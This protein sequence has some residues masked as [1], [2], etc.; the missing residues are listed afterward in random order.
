MTPQ[1]PVP[2]T[3][4]DLLSR[5]LDRQAAAQG[6]GLAMFEAGQVTPYDAGPVQ[7]IDP[8]PAWAEAVTALG[9]TW[10]GV[11]LA[12]P[13][14]WPQLVAS[15]EPVVA[16]AWCVGN[17]P[18]LVRNFHAILRYDNLAHLRPAGGRPVNAPALLEWA[19]QVAAQ[20]QFPEAILAVGAL[21]L[22]QHFDQ[23]SWLLETLDRDVPAAW[24]AVWVNER[25]ALAWHRGDADEAVRQWRA[26]EPTLPVRFNRAMADLFSG[27]AVDSVSSRLKELVVHLP[28]TSGW[29]HLARLYLALAK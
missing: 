1:R 12:P 29:H 16:L 21:R 28:E 3:L 11:K 5:Y 2:P 8:Q 24:R 27:N 15:H 13:P 26:A 25:A 7:P 10:A 18:Q 23:A 17:F 22:A 19:Q 4:D 14:H 9:P 20:Q 6:E